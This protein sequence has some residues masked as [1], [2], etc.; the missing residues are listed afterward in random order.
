MHLR[1]KRDRCARGFALAEAVVGVGVVG[2]LVA[3]L[4][5][6][7]T[8]GFTTEQLDREDLRA[9][10]ILIEKMDQLRVISWEQLLDSTVV[11]NSFVA[12]F[13]PDDTP[14]LRRRLFLPPAA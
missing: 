5:T 2:M 13:N 11:P 1:P 3:A 7:V 6:A 9:T 14:V 10:Q 12:T 4:Y 8:T